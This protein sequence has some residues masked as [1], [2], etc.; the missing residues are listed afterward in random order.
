MQM[1]CRLLE[2]IFRFVSVEWA[3]RAVAVGEGVSV[4]PLGAGGAQ[5]WC[6]DTRECCS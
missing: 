5:C 6:C 1:L 4:L 2:R 3:M